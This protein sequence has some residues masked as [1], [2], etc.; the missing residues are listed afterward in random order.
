M[1]TSNR[2]WYNTKPRR[3]TTQRGP[4]LKEWNLDAHSLKNAANDNKVIN[5]IADGINQRKAIAERIGMTYTRTCHIIN[6]LIEAEVLISQD[7]QGVFLAPVSGADKSTM[8]AI[9]V[10]E[11]SQ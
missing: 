7:R 9:A 10:K 11:D 1:K 4:S 6:R 3:L 8:S 5:A 2:I